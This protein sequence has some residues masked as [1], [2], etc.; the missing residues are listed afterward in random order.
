MCPAS[1]L[2]RHSKNDV[3]YYSNNY[4][5]RVITMDQVKYRKMQSRSAHEKARQ[6]HNCVDL[7]IGDGSDPLGQLS[8]KAVNAA[9]AIELFFKSILI[10]YQIKYGKQ[11]KLLYLFKRLPQEIENQ[12][13]SI[14]ELEE[15]QFIEL[16][17]AETNAFEEWRYTFEDLLEH[18]IYM[19][20][21]LRLLVASHKASSKVQRERG[22][23]ATS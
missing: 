7:I 11:H 14:M 19:D 10:S 4:K 15:S 6:F 16:L 5:K 17:T 9:F 13:I 20:F 23:S 12:I 3:V 21:L 18:K 22:L 8:I 2:L 1:F